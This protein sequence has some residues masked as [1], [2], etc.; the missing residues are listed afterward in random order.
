MLTDEQTAIS[1]KAIMTGSVRG[2]AHDLANSLHNLCGT[3]QLL[4]MEVKN[5][6]DHCKRLNGELI[7]RL[8]DECGRM[9]SCLEE[10]R[11]FP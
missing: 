1:K 10:L 4:E 7:I 2:I 3:L 9:Q 8:K 5:H 6:Q 11:H